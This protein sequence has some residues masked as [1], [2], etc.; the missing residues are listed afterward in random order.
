MSDNFCMN[1]ASELGEASNCLA[2]KISLQMFAQRCD[3]YWISTCWKPSYLYDTTSFPSPPFKLAFSPP[4]GISQRASPA[5]QPPFHGTEQSFLYVSFIPL[6][7]ASLIYSWLS[8]IRTEPSHSGSLHNVT[9]FN[10][11]QTSFMTNV[12]KLNS[13]TI[14]F[15]T[16]LYHLEIGPW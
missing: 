10:V 8:G 9:F 6:A 5:Y 12:S 1:S 2:Q 3:I 13:S 4:L 11:S 15:L 7:P 14:S 16:A